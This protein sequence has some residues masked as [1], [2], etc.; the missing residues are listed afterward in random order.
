MRRKIGNGGALS[1]PPPKIIQSHLRVW[2]AAIWVTVQKY[3]ISANL[4][5]AGK[6]LCDK[7]V[8]A[9]QMSGSTGEW[10]RTT[11]E[12]RQGCLPS[13][14]L[15]IIFLDRIMCMEE[16]DRKVQIGRRTITHP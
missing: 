2:H 10:L 11:V 3:N 4:V 8:S 15:F 9:V 13:Q 5:R 12:V 14:T 6:H 1:P 16:N 7:A